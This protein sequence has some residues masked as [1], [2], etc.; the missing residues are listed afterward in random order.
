[1]FPMVHRAA[2]TLAIAALAGISALPAQTTPTERAAAG[3]V[4]KTI[5]SLQ[6]ALAP[7]STGSRL[8]AAK[9]RS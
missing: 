7:M 8:V 1:M 3:T 6:V 2:L 9:V 5:D 4:L